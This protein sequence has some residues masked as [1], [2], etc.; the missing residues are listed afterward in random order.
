[1]SVATLQDMLNFIYRRDFDIEDVDI[2]NLV[3]ISAFK[4]GPKIV[5]KFLCFVSV[6]RSWKLFD[7][8]NNNQERKIVN[9]ESD[10]K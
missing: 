9:F 2:L 5:C 8:T 6:L 7:T 4:I 10:Q 3:N 1:M